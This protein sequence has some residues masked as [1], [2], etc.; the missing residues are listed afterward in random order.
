MGNL[1]PRPRPRPRRKNPSGV[2]CAI[3]QVTSVLVEYVHRV[4]SA[5]LSML[6]TTTLEPGV[7]SSFSR[8]IDQLFSDLR[9]SAV[10]STMAKIAVEHGTRWADFATDH[11]RPTAGTTVSPIVFGP[12][13]LGPDL[14]LLRVAGA[15]TEIEIEGLAADLKKS[16]AK[17][18]LDGHSNRE[19]L[20][21]LS[22]RVQ[23]STGVGI[24]RARV[25]ART[26]TIRSSAEAAISRYRTNGIERVEFWAEMDSKACPACIQYHGK[27]YLIGEAPVIPIHPNCRCCYLPVIDE[28]TADGVT[29]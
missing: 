28:E 21:Q 25:I 9:N 18:L 7:Y 20:S 11:A 1:R 5:A 4:R 23:E 14:A 27:I 26:E 22:R 16:L 19:T 13:R 2:N 29:R 24:R 12:L 3:A 8:P 15:R 6:K 17:T 10:G